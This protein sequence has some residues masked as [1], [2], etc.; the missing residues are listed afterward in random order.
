[1]GAGRVLIVVLE[2]GGDVLAL[3]DGLVLDLYRHTVHTSQW[4][5]CTHGELRAGRV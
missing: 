1:V 3:V 5:E 2:D 4:D